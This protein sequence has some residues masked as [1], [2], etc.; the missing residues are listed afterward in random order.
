MWLGSALARG[1]HHVVLLAR[2]PRFGRPIV[3]WRGVRIE[4]YR[5]KREL[6][7]KAF[8]LARKAD[9]TC[10]GKCTSTYSLT[11]F[12]AVRAAHRPLLVD[13]DDWDAVGGTFSF[14]Q[15]KGPITRAAATFL[16][17]WL[18]LR[19]HAVTVASPV[20]AERLRWMG[21]DPARVFVVSNGADPELFNPL[22]AEVGGKEVKRKFGLENGFV[23]GL[24]GVMYRIGGG[25]DIALKAFIRVQREVSNAYLLLAGHGPA[26]HFVK[27]AS[28][29]LGVAGRV[30]VTGTI[31]HVEVPK[32]IGAM[33]V[34]L[35]PLKIRGA[36]VLF[37]AARSNLKLYEYAAWGKPIA[38]ADVGLVSELLCSGA[39]LMVSSDEPRD[40]AEAV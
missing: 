31:P 2:P 23:V 8:A 13:L 17:E 20:L 11:A 15:N 10:L 16:E 35:H 40:Y 9:V 4:L 29:K 22:A 25:V 34:C 19:A 28:R 14:P 37:N 21:V 18:P 36:E 38:G 7:L 1:G 6:L 5:S 26:V 27:E 3:K 24:A 32:Y 30:V 12:L 39:G 33:D